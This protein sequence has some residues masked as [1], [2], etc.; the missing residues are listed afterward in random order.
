M[1]LTKQEHD[2]LY[3]WITVNLIPTKTFNDRKTSYGL[4]H[5]F[6]RDDCGFYIDNDD[7]KNIMLEHGFKVKNPNDTNWIFN[8]S[9]RSPALLK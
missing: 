4:K 2:I 5:I 1:S 8:I 9:K 3:D 6:E 7:F